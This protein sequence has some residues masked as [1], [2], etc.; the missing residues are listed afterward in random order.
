[1]FPYI[2]ICM[3]VGLSIVKAI[4]TKTKTPTA[5]AANFILQPSSQW[6]PIKHSTSTKKM[7]NKQNANSLLLLRFFISYESTSYTRTL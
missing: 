2:L 6:A 5:H 1:M 3:H 4:T 7:W